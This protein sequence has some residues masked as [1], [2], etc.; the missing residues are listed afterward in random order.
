[1]NTTNDNDLELTSD[2]AQAKPEDHLFTKQ[3]F[4]SFVESI[5]VASK[6]DISYIDATIT[7]AEMMGIELSDAQ[8]YLTLP[9]RDMIRKQAIDENM[10]RKVAIMEYDKKVAKQKNQSVT[11]PIDEALFT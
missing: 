7:L 9:L 11:M 2:P 4:S 6:G 10:I 1:M 5:V 3:K 8:K